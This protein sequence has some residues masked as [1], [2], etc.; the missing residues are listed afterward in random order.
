MT[1]S[2]RIARIFGIDVRLHV[3]FLAL[4][5]FLLGWTFLP[6]TEASPLTLLALGALFL[7]AALHEFGHALVARRLGVVVEDILFLPIL[8]MARLRLPERPRT[9]LAVAAAGPAVN[10]VLAGILLAAAPALGVAPADLLAWPTSFFALVFWVNLLMGTVNLLPAF[11]MDGGRCLRALLAMRMDHAT[12]TRL[13]VRSGL[14]VVL[15]AGT[16]GFLLTRSAVIPVAA[17]FLVYLGQRELAAVEQR[18]RRREMARL[19]DELETVAAGLPAEAP[20]VTRYGDFRRLEDPRF[21][22]M[23]DRYRNRLERIREGR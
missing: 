15:V 17:V 14:V 22:E 12:A 1:P 2:I 8:L 5:A 20:T 9:E 19:R 3:T 16:A 6:G 7:I 4:V 18:A 23:F 21:R 13:A 11:P 10:L